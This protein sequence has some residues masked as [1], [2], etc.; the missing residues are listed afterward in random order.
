MRRSR[1]DHLNQRTY[2]C[3]EFE[4]LRENEVGS[5]TAGMDGDR[6]RTGR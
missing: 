2:V 5:P 6:K 3:S 1:K 4:Q